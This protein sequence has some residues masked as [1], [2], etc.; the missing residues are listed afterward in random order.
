M[1]F[2]SSSE[3]LSQVKNI[4][5]GTTGPTG[6]IG[7]QGLTGAT[8]P[9]GA[10]GNTG[11]TGPQGLTGATGPQGAAGITGA[12]GPAFPTG[13]SRLSLPAL[14]NFASSSASNATYP[15]TTSGA[16]GILT[17]VYTAQ[18]AS[19]TS[20]PFFFDVFLNDSDPARPDVLA[21][22]QKM[23]MT[24]NSSF[25][26]QSQGGVTFSVPCLPTSNYSLYI[27]YPTTP[28]IVQN[29]VYVYLNT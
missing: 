17:I 20:S 27:A 10:S 2:L 8:G 12:T 11:A 21:G 15:I 22:Q 13:L 25:S 28:D 7:P 6:P 3:Y 23:V 26:L 29:N 5:C 24:F 9:Q 19:S 18:F 14:A 16:K 4:Q 1:V